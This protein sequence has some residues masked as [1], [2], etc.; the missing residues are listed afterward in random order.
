MS[1]GNYVS[2]SRQNG[3]VTFQA[4]E[5]SRVPKIVPMSFKVK[6]TDHVTDEAPVTISAYLGLGQTAPI[7][8]HVVK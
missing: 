2:F 3:S 4:L 5:V 1:S 6:I 7:T 8:P